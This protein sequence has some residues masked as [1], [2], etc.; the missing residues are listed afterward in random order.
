LAADPFLAGPAI[1][2]ADFHLGAMIAYFTLAPEGLALL[3]R[4]PRLAA[5]WRQVGRR[6]SFAATDPGLPSA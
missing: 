3:E 4:H 5:W 1:S 6:P 2:L